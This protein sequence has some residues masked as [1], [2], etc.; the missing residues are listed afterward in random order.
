MENVPYINNRRRVE[1]KKTERQFRKKWLDILKVRP[2]LN[3]FHL[4]R[5]RSDLN[6][7]KNI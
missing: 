6:E 1:H 7:L 2:E 4:E 3:N 5:Y